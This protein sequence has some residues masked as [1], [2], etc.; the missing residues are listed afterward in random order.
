MID[1]ATIRGEVLR[2][3]AGQ[4]TLNDFNAWL[5]EQTWDIPL[6]DTSVAA[7]SGSIERIVSEYDAGH[8][9][10]RDLQAGLISLTEP[11]TPSHLQR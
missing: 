11:A 4:Q 6:N 7:I 5:I 8:L 1:K 9:S 2:Y 3:L 10:L